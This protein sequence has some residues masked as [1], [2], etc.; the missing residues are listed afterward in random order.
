MEEH[1]LEEY[2][3]GEPTSWQVNR[4]H[5]YDVEGPKPFT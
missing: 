3:M 5:E 2:P 4:M 1:L